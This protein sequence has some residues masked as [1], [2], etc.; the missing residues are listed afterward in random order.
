MGTPLYEKLRKE[1]DKFKETNDCTV[2]A[3]SVVTGWSYKKSHEVM[4][5]DTG[6][7]RG[8]GVHYGFW[9]THYMEDYGFKYDVIDLKSIIKKKGSGL[10]GKTVAQWLPKRG[11]FLIMMSGHVAAVKAGQLHDWSADRK[12]RVQKI[13]KIY[14]A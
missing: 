8:E 12:N 10:T 13:Y 14:K 11:R 3:T 2:I 1:S 9:I 7:Q 5:S 6:R 4:A